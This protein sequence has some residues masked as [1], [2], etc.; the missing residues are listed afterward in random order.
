L[1]SALSILTSQKLVFT[2]QKLVFSLS[3][4]LFTL[5]LA[6]ILAMSTPTGGA[7]D[8]IAHA[9]HADAVASGQLVGRREVVTLPPGEHLI[10]AGFD[11]DPGFARAIE[12]W[13]P[14][15]SF[16]AADVLRAQRAYWQGSR[17]FI[18]MTP[19]TAYFPVLYVPAALA[20]TVA[21]LTAVGPFKAFIAARLANVVVFTIISLTSLALARR[22]HALL[23]CVL[24]L[25][26]TV[27][28]AASINPDG[29]LVAISAV[30]AALATRETRAFP[31]QPS[32]PLRT[33]IPMAV[34]VGVVGL[35]KFPYV[36]MA[37]LLL[38]PIHRLDRSIW[39]RAGLAVLVVIPGLLW[40]GYVMT[41]VAVPWPPMPPYEAG[42]LWPGPPGAIFHSPAA[43]SQLLVIFDNPL[44][45]I[46][47]TWNTISHDPW[48]YR[49]AVGLLGFLTVPLP[50]RVYQVWTVSLFS[51]C[52]ATMLNDG[53]SWIASINVGDSIV[54]VA[55]ICIGAIAIYMSQYLTW[56][57]VGAATAFGPTGR[58]LLPLA[59][60]AVLALPTF[61]GRGLSRLRGI[62][63]GATCVAACADLFEVPPIIAA[64]YQ[65]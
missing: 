12:V 16:T 13:Y 22:G 63:V 50:D 30:I 59:P 48:L 42:P 4:L 53:R 1:P 34:L 43:G 27:S 39:H 38:L 64:L 56:T 32:P 37:L 20:T 18:Q 55:I 35:A 36:V 21:K 47:I 24:S 3:F 60:S 57:Q 44:R 8:E 28:L 23:F 14:N 65:N 61:S 9:L 5:P 33:R 7:P 51:A 49:S 31:G 25:P 6:L 58:Y 62:F 52:L 41:K 40:V 2:S 45:I 17:V 19:L 10:G 11:V 29:L 15:M 26:M 54:V 46:T